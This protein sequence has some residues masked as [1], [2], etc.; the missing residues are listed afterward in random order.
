MVQASSST[1]A[2]ESSSE[3]SISKR[4]REEPYGPS[5]AAPTMTTMSSRSALTSPHSGTGR[6]EV[7]VGGAGSAGMVASAAASSAAAAAASCACLDSSGRSSLARASPPV[8]S[9]CWGP[10][11][12]T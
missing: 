5:S 10:A 11:A 12:V 2:A 9:I 8:R 6:A 1:P 3:T 4:V 7:A